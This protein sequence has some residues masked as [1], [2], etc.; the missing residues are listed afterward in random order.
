MSDFAQSI[1]ILTNNF[2]FE[3]V[4]EILGWASLIGFSIGWLKRTTLH[5]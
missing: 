4:F 3:V 1:G 5:D 2:C